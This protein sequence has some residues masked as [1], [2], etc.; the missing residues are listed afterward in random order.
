MAEGP[1]DE[2]I[3]RTDKPSGP[4]P[5]ASPSIVTLLALICSAEP[6]STPVARPVLTRCD[7]TAAPSRHGARTCGPGA[8]QHAP[9]ECSEITVEVFGFE[10]SW[11]GTSTRNQRWNA[12]RSAA[13]A[14]NGAESAGTIRVSK[15]RARMLTSTVGII[16]SVSTCGVDRHRQG[17]R[18]GPYTPGSLFSREAPRSLEALQRAGEL[19]LCGCRCIEAVA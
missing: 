5:T 15:S 2:T 18:L 11:T 4:T 9:H 17:A 6:R 13:F 3:P 16:F 8:A 14:G 10:T 12:E 19:V 7:Y 1:P